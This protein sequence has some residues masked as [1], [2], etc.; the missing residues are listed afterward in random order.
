MA[1]LKD[2]L[3]PSPP[4]G[5]CRL[6][7]VDP[8]VF[9]EWDRL[10]LR[11]PEADFFHTS[12]WAKVLTD[13]YHYR[14]AYYC[15]FEDRELAAAIPLM[16]VKGRL[17][18]KRGVSLPFADSCEPLARPGQALIDLWAGIV[19]EGKRRGWKS[20][21]IR[22]RAEGL[23]AGPSSATFLGHTLDLSAGEERIYAS[24]RENTK[25]NIRKAA[26]ARVA[27]TF[28]ASPDAVTEFYRL[29][30]LTRR[31]QGRP[32]QPFHFFKKIQEHV[33]APGRGFAALAAYHGHPVAGA[34]Y[35]EFNG[36][37]IYAYAA[38]DKAY[39]HLRADHLLMW[40]AV[41]RLA[42]SG[43]RALC[44]GRTEPDNKERLQFKDGW[45]AAQ[46]KIE[47]RRYDFAAETFLARE[48]K[49]APVFFQQF[50]QKAPAPVLKW[51][52]SFL[53]GHLG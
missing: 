15:L 2:I 12:S 16:E 45:G 42:G 25:R 43:C 50:F 17:T 49:P 40:E 11:F 38:A 24:F 37:A 48:K 9:P 5:S 53:S 19:R 52:G 46:F 26:Q 1:S 21:E 13:S 41:R 33:L 39:Q 27:V 36:R 14:P 34:L 22:S 23:P 35:F 6:K 28:S 8:A 31:E 7:V 29:N 18:G 3:S 51:I 4:A 47:Y 30:C 10:L 44:F 32:P 20:V